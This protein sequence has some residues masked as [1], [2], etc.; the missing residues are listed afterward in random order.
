MDIV[1]VDPHD[2]DVLASWHGVLHAVDQADRPATADTWSLDEVRAE[3]R[4]DS[5]YWRRLAFVARDAGRTVGAAWLAL[6]LQDNRHRGELFVAV[7]PS[8]R[9]RGVGTAL[10]DHLEDIARTEG[11][12]VAGAESDWPT[13]A[14]PKGAGW[15]G[16]EFLA[17][18]G[19]EQVLLDVQ[20]RLSLPVP[21][22][23]LDEL[24]AQAGAHT[25]GYEL[26]SW[27]GPVPEEH[28]AG[29][30]ALDASLET[31]AP[32]GG[33]DLEPRA[34]AIAKV[35]E[36]E[37]LFAAQGRTSYATVALDAAG[38][39]VAYTQIAR[40][41][42]GTGKAYQEGT[43]VRRDHRGHRLGLAVKVANLRLLQDAGLGDVDRLVTYNAASNEHMIAVNEALGFRVVEWAGEF[44]KRL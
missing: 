41:R 29:W 21:S 20:R 11:R 30:A 24:A 39:V 9:R 26:R 27:V 15:P 7:L 5:G 40:S 12:T 3:L 10:L 25:D 14:G 6:S 38:E 28:V 34:A 31:E 32:T 13:V 4:Q 2:E 43:L 22:G 23:L 35:R 19:Y 36:D 17:G 37:Q 18:R 8:A 44:Q 42:D 33:L 16:P 1:I